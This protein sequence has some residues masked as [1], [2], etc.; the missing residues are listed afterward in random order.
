[1]ESKIIENGVVYNSSK[2]EI[3]GYTKDIPNDLI[4]P[5]SVTS[6]GSSAFSDC[7]SLT[8]VTIP[9]SV[10]SIGNSAFY[11]CDSLTSITV[12]EDNPNY[13]SD[14]YGA[15][16]NKDKTMLIQYP[17]GN[18]R[19]SYTI[20]D[21]VTSI[22]DYAFYDCTSLT[23]ITIPNSVTS[24]GNGVFEDCTGLTSVTIGNSVTSIG[25]GAF[26]RCTSLTSITIPD[27]V[28]SIGY[29]AFRYCTGLTSVTIPDSVTSIGDW[30]FYNCTG[31]TSVT[32]PDSVTSIG[33]W[34]FYNC[35]GLTSVTIPDS[36]TS[37]GNYAFYDCTS[38]TSITVKEGN[39]NYSSD[40]YGVL[41][42]KDKTLLIQY[43]IGNTRTSYTIPDSVTSI[44]DSAFRYCTSLTSVT[45]PDS[46][47]SIGYGA[48][49]Y[50][51]GLT[52]VTIPN[53]VTSIGKYAFYNC[54]NLVKT[55]YFKATNGNMTC[56]DMVYKLGTKY[57]QQNVSLCKKGF[58][59][60]ENA[61]DLLN[62]YNGQIGKDVRFFTI[63]CEDVSPQTGW[64]SKR[65]CGTIKLV[66]EITSYAELLNR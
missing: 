42:N 37:I 33:D 12:K 32:I 43:P 54:I 45:I 8:S 35:T 38:L 27:S 48:F 46:V 56:R 57:Y 28:T 17:I 16:F 60:C 14:E 6:I 61:Y 36:V 3:L 62:Y 24:I 26:R 15:L 52:S 23:S 59:F 47:T 66:R 51:T 9:D 5:D 7:E 40:E 50:C 25:D 55:G 11:S 20:P 39:P 53:S 41:F 19:T 2:E 13:S 58:H 31:L 22:D 64:D 44:G 1:M 34:A 30:A 4:I 10:T 21:S 49:R 29:G 65:V 18:T 63:E